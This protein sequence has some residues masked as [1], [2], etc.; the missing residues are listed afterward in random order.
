MGLTEGDDELLATAVLPPQHEHRI[1]SYTGVPVM[2]EGRL[3]RPR[4]VS[5]EKR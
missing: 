3:Q 1:R 5:E 2:A 4:Q